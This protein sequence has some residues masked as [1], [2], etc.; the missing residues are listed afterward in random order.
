MV[1]IATE[2]GIRSQTIIQSAYRIHYIFWPPGFTARCLVTDRYLHTG[3]IFSIYI[4]HS[5]TL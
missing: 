3:C 5:N 1:I 4:G 2:D